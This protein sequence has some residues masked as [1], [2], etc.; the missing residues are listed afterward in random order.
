MKTLSLVSWLLIPAAAFSSGASSKL[1]LAFEPNQGQGNSESKFFARGPGYT[2]ALRPDGATI[3]SKG[4]SGKREVT[5]MRLIGA[6]S[7]SKP[8][9]KDPLPGTVNYFIG[10]DSKNWRSNLPTYSKVEFTRTYPGIDMVYYGS[11][12]RLEYDFV[13]QPGGNPASIRMRFSGASRAKLAAN[14][15]LEVGGILQHKPVA[16]QNFAGNGRTEIACRYVLRANQ[17]VALELGSYDRRY[18]LIID[19]VISYAS[20]V[21]GSGNDTVASIKVDASGNLYM[22]GYTTSANF[23]VRGAA[24]AAYAGSNSPI[25]QAQFGDAFVAKLNPGGTAMLYA[26]YLG[27]SG[28]DFATSLSIDAAGNAYIVGATQSANFP[29]TAGALQRTYKGFTPADD[30]GFYNPG[31][32]F[33]AKLNPT[34]SALMYST[35]LG[36][37]LNDLPMGVATDSNGNAI[38]VG[39]TKSSDFPT[40]ANALSKTYRGA[41]NTGPAVGGDAFVSILN[42]AGTALTYSTFLGGRGHDLARGVAVDAQNNI[43]VCGMTSSGDFPVT[44]GALQST[45]QGNENL[46]D[47]NHPVGHGFVAKISAQGTIVYATFLGGSLRDGA[48]AIAVDSTGAAYVAGGTASADFPTTANAPQKAYKGQGSIGTLGDLNYGDAFV[49]KLNAA[50]SALV[51][52]TFVGGSADETASDIAIDSA[53]NAYITGFTLSNDFPVTP[54]ALQAANAGFGGQGL[55]PNASQGFN[56]ERVRNSGDAFLVKLSAAGALTYSSFFGGKNDDAGLAIAVDAA[57]NAYV[58]GN[59]LSTTLA[60]SSGTLQQNYGGAGAQFP[61]GDGFV[62][63]FD[64]GGKLPSPPASVSVVPGFAASGAAGATLTT[65]FTVEVVDTQGV[66]LAGIAVT[67]SATSAT[68]NPASAITDAQGRA[69]TTVTL[70]ATVGTAAITATVAGIPVATANVAIGAVTPL[71]V[72]KA[73]VN[74]AS[75]QS[76]IAPGSW[77]TV[78]IDQTA[79]TNTTASV[80]PLPTTLG[81]YRILVNGAPI[82]MYLVYSLQPGTQLNAQLPYEIPVGTAQVVVEANGVASAQFPFAVQAGAPGI[83]VFGDNRAVAQNVQPDGSLIVNTVDVPVPAGDYIIAYLTGQGALDNPVPSGNIKTGATLSIPKL[84]YSATLGGKP[85]TVAFLGMTPGQISLAQAN[86]LIPADTLPGTYPLVIT[87]GTAPSNGPQI[88]VTTKRP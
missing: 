66:K 19:P 64:F 39:T 44:P 12:G 34:G 73:I 79:A 72:V 70:G 65:P 60:T 5:V 35:Y 6:S 27:G 46:R 43:Y 50:G 86:I 4:K 85:V 13:V 63:K 37:A 55:A 9:A 24:Q 40:T 77:I 11:E 80:V 57:G 36:G 58:A 8:M 22:A 16:Y 2:V 61:R 41:S 74:G 51:Y 45:Y 7:T 75:F 76:T 23:P 25:E 38:I 83:F 81:G 3:H 47:F 48:V 32:G 71:P 29:T 10:S 84:S 17:E 88:S 59:T 28:D 30:N 20:Y 21:G 78:Y 87:I 31:D 14:G 69:S 82:P 42:A 33:V 56:T 49:S 52:S 68:V 62:V 1:P 54:D 67:F 15:D 26:T 18:P 53:G